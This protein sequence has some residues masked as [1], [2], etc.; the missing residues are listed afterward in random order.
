M[1]DAFERELEAR[2]AAGLGAVT[3]FVAA[4]FLDV[5]GTGFADRRRRHV[6]RI[7]YAFSSLDFTL[8]WRMMLRYPGL[9]VV[10]V[11]GMAVGIAVATGAFTIVAMLM[12]TRLP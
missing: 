6:V 2:R 3:T 8:A 10:G 11:F 5:I 9:S 12:D 1:L 7:G 4:A